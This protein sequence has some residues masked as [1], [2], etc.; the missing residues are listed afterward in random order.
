MP[1][2]T[3][4]DYTDIFPLYIKMGNTNHFVDPCGPVHSGALGSLLSYGKSWGSHFAKNQTWFSRTE[5]DL[6]QGGFYTVKFINQVEDY[7]EIEIDH[8]N[9]RHFDFYKRD[10]QVVKLY[11]WKVSDKRK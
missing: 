5:P 4:E 10:G 9:S 8:S 3:I 6:D 7:I 2:D 11:F 1:I